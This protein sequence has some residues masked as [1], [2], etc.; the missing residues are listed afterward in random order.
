M[1]FLLH[2]SLIQAHCSKFAV[3]EGLPAK[4]FA[5]ITPS[6][7]LAVVRKKDLMSPTERTSALTMSPGR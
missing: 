1:R 7:F 6:S 5:K 4:L 2:L 3:D